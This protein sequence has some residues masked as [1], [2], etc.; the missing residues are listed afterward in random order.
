MH[1]TPISVLHPRRLGS[2]QIPAE[3][4]PVGI[5][6]DYKPSLAM[7]PDGELVMVAFHPEQRQDGTYREWT[8]LWRSTDGARTWSQRTVLLDVIGREQWLTAT[9]DG[10]LF[11]TSHILMRDLANRDGVVHSLVHRS[12]DRGRTWRRTKVLLTGDLRCGQPMRP[13]DG[14]HTSR[15]V[16]ELPDGT[17]LLGVSIGNSAVGYMWRSTDRGATWDPGRPVT[18]GSYRGRPYDNADGF[19]AEDF[20]FRT[21]SG[22]LLH[23]IRCGPP[24][25]MYGLDD[26]RALPQGSD[27][28]DRTLVCASQDDGQ[29]WGD[30][31]DF[32][33]YG[34]MY[35]RVLRLQDGRL[36]LTCTQRALFPPLGL[37]AL[38]S[39]DDGETWSFDADALILEARTPTGLSSGGGFGNTVQLADGT[40]VSAYSYRTEDRETQVEAMRWRL[41][42]AGGD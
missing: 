15:N 39:Y 3:R 27:Q 14:G 2:W 12:V 21:S 1:T 31:R 22:R 38:L 20:T 17:L 30:L 18:I 42:V 34:L 23:W 32:G 6:G 25:P 40:L 5:P 10:V 11:M 37:R 29:T 28:G 33:D 41:P 35:V 26:G 4:I 8:V 9:S 24:S 13:G 16:V 36:L 19:F 7:L